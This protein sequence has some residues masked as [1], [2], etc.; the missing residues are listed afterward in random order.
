MRSHVVL[1]VALLAG[2]G[3][4]DGQIIC[5]SVPEGAIAHCHPD[6]GR[7][8]DASGPCNPLTQEG[9]S[10]GE[11]CTWLLDANVPEHVGHVGCA[12]SGT[13]MVG[14][15]CLFGAP[16]T[17]GVDNCIAGLVCS[18]VQGE[19]TCRELCDLEGGDPQCGIVGT[20][21]AHASIFVTQGMSPTVGLC[22]ML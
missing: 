1:L 10:V 19:G 12:P 13:A 2:C 21:T 5:R 20:C 15:P 11:K 9:C 6:A 16:G 3:G 14:D 18:T 8:V 22:E 4:D 7:P 17:T